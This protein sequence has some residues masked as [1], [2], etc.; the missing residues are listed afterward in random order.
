MPFNVK[1]AQPSI[2]RVLNLPANRLL[3]MFNK[4]IMPLFAYKGGRRKRKWLK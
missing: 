1:R 2:N 4:K 3:A